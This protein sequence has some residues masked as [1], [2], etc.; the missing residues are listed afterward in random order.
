MEILRHVSNNAILQPPADWSQDT[1]ECTPLAVTIVEYEDGGSAI[2]SYWKP[3]AEE[4][5]WLND[6]A[7]IALFVFG[8]G[9]PPVAVAV[10]VI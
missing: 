5:Q 7:A 10:E 9:M 4:L 2:K 6:G 1:I 3:S 8:T